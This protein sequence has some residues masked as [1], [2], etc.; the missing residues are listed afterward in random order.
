[1]KNYG[2]LG[3]FGGWLLLAVKLIFSW[4]LLFFSFPCFLVVFPGFWKNDDSRLSIVGSWLLLAVNLMVR[5]VEAAQDFPRFS[6]GPQVSAQ[7]FDKTVV[8]CFL[9]GFSAVFIQVEIP[10]LFLENCDFLLSFIIRVVLVI[11][12]DWDKIGCSVSPNWNWPDCRVKT[13]HWKPQQ[14]Q[15]S[16]SHVPFCLFP[17]WLF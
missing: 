10:R 3:I 14:A 13:S 7:I 16:V 12:L 6:P 1:M 17:F 2:R 4:F 5:N 11:Q 8:S 9:S 15:Q